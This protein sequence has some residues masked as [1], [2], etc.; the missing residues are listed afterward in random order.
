[1]KTYHYTYHTTLRFSEPVSGHSFSLRCMPESNAFQAVK[2]RK[3]AVEPADSLTI[4]RDSW[5]NGIVYGRKQEAH[6]SFSY[7]SSGLVE[8]TPYEIPAR[9]DET[10]F[11]LPTPLTAYQP[12]ME[13]L[14][15]DALSTPAGSPLQSGQGTNIGKALALSDSIYRYLSYTPG[16]TQIE[17]PASLVFAQ[18]KGVCQ[19]Y[20]HLLIALC[21]HLGLPARYVNGFM[22]GTG[23]TH[24]WV[25]LLEGNRWLGID[26]TNNQFI[27]YGYIKLSHGRDA[28]DCPVNRGL[29][30]GGGVQTA[31]IQVT[32]EAL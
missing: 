12:A 29:F 8:M 14:I 25:E 24:A 7:G 19:D 1:M 10:R 11:L 22:E 31:D 5:G 16:S 21:R 20:A 3:L 6:S 27:T 26:P 13:Q 4:G 28:M 30:V 2:E 9:E 23:V 32:V 17:T 15:H 18:R